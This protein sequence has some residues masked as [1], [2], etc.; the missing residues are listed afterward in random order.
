MERRFSRRVFF[1]GLGATALLVRT[2]SP[3]AAEA[4]WRDGAPAEW[5]R[6]LAAAR[7]EGQVTVAAFPQLAEKMTIKNFVDHGPNTETGQPAVYATWAPSDLFGLLPD[8]GR[9][10][11]SGVECHLVCVGHLR[12]EADGPGG[13]VDHVDDVGQQ[14]GGVLVAGL[15]RERHRPAQPGGRGVLV[16]CLAGLESVLDGLG[17]FGLP[18]VMGNRRAERRLAPTTCR[19]LVRHSGAASQ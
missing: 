11:R 4:G 8:P 15:V 7:T 1:G 18:G 10:G 14:A 6:V 17:E 2:E 16:A 3:K 13:R 19:S 9:L 5:E 12:L